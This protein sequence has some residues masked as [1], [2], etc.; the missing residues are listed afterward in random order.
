MPIQTWVRNF[1]ID[2]QDID[3]ITNLLLE[4][5]RP[6]SA[7]VLARALVER[8]LSREADLVR[9]RYK[10]TLQYNPSNAYQIGQRL[11]FPA[12]EYQMAE[13]VSVRAGSNE[14]YGTFNVIGVKFDDDRT[15]E[16]AAELT[17]PH[18][19]SQTVASDAHF[20]SD[21]LTVDDIMNNARSAVVAQVETALRANSDLVS[22]TGLWF[23]RD[24]LLDVN[25]GHLNLTE[26][27]LD[28]MNG[29]PLSPEEIVEQIGGIADAPL[30]L[31]TFSLN[32][33]MR[34]DKRFDEVGS[35]GEVKWFLSRLEPQEVLQ[36]PAYLRYT[37]T[38]YDH[39]LL[40]PELIAL[41]A[42]INDELSPEYE[43]SVANPES[44]V[45]TLNYP[46]R[47]VGTLPMT[48][49]LYEILPTARK[50]ARIWM[51]LLDGQD[52]DLF[53]GWV[54]HHEGYVVGLND[55]YRKHRIPVGALLTISRTES[56]DTIKIDFNAHRARTEYIRLLVPKNDQISFENHKRQIG[57]DYDELMIVGVEDVAG[58]DALS[59]QWRNRS[60]VSILKAILPGLARLNPQGTVHAKTIY[61]VFNVL[62]RCP[63]GPIFAT[64]VANPDFENVGGHYWRMVEG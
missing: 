33:A 61:S 41:E 21:I 14:D 32:Y 6:L 10:D 54:A 19:L 53:T 18:K 31:Q 15:R 4:Q 12:L 36:T 42:E 38:E 29:G 39:S 2:K 58:V 35:T 64:L 46:H 44:A 50:T 48:S 7:D 17:T 45:V 47:R 56:S 5:E 51:R 40:T 55:Y 59:Q 26:A 25:M 27:V 3:F 49:A 28:M 8:K 13:V 11:V 9:E 63:P 62:R 23:P 30:P 52:G 43:S 1:S 37:P 20:L 16:F 57:A 22:L 34:E 24:L 60:N